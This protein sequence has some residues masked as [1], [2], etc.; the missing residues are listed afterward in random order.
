[1]DTD[2]ANEPEPYR[3]MSRAQLIRQIQSLTL[4][5]ARRRREK[6]YWKTLAQ[7]Q[8]SGEETRQGVE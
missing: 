3:H 2:R 4:E 6:R 1:M 7:Q 8:Q 5:S